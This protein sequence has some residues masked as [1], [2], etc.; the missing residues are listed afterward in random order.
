MPG[1]DLTE[2]KFQLELC[3]NMQEIAHNLRMYTQNTIFSSLTMKNLVNDLLD[4]AKIQNSC[5]TLN[6][7]YFNLIEV[8]QEAFSI[9]QFHAQQKDISLMLELNENTP[10]MFKRVYSDRNRFL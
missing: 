1:D 3:K 6:N 7:D 9:I 5:F 8:V 4:V 10:S 2:C